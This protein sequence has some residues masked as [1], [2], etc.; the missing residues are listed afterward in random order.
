MSQTIEAIYENGV[1]K[2]L[3]PV[4][5]P[6][7]TTVEIEPPAVNVEEQVRQQLTSAG[8]SPTDIE[9]ILDNFRA[10][11]ES[12]STLTDEQKRILEEARLDQINFFNRPVL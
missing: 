4:H 10:L 3:Q 12:Y 2:P 9:R 11:W 1:F 7:G 6:E 8:A 5:L